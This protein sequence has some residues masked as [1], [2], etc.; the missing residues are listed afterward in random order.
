[1]KRK[2]IFALLLAAVLLITLTA[3]GERDNGGEDAERPTLRAY[4]CA[5][6][7]TLDPAMESDPGAQSIIAA[8]YEG[9]MRVRSDGSGNAAATEG[10]AKEYTVKNNYDN[11]VTYTFTLRSSARWSDGEKVS[12][13]DFVYA[14]RRL[15]DPKRNSPNSALLRMVSG[16]DTVQKTGDTAALGVEALNESTFAVKLTAPCIYF[17]DTVCTSPA[18]VPLRADVVESTE[19]WETHIPAVTNGP[20]TVS[21]WERGK[22]LRAVC[23]PEYYE[24]RLVTLDGVD[25]VFA[26]SPDEAYTRW[27]NGEIDYIARLSDRASE[28]LAAEQGDAFAPRPLAVTCCALYNHMTDAFSVDALRQAFDMA[29]DREALAEA[30]G[31]TAVPA[32]GLVPYGV[33]SDPAVAE[34]FR[35]A[36]GDLFAAYPQEAAERS[37]AIRGLLADGGQSLSALRCIYADGSV[38]QAAVDAAV[39]SW[40]RELGVDI[41]PEPLTQEEFDRCV[42]EGDFD[43]ALS[44]LAGLYN[45]P[46]AFL[47]P[48]RSEHSVLGYSNPTYDLLLGVAESATDTVARSAFLHDAEAMVLE[49]CAVSPLYFESAA[50]CSDEWSGILTDCLGRSYFTAAVPAA[51]AEQNV[52]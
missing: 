26:A 6:P 29:L 52:F 8:L 31:V 35:T 36:G 22:G 18:A 43:I 28:E 16:Y 34:D 11:T 17:L 7:Q 45:D 3:C 1:M 13:D 5:D 9:L 33:T 24:N 48:L 10:V 32:A 4:V 38:P 49:D 14:W 27:K 51:Q 39:G 20:F 41:T 15:A 47:A 37:A 25:F 12:A 46:M 30:A 42:A 21:V 19:G 44:K 2:R 40:R 50:V 23:N